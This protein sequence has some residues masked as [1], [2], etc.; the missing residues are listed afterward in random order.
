MKEYTVP[1]RIV[2][3]VMAEGVD[4]I[5]G[6]PDPSFFAMFLEAE[7][8]GM[9]IIAPHHEQAGALMADG[10][11]R[12]TGKPGVMGINKGPGVAN[13][14]AGAAYLAKENIPAV[15]IMGQRQRLYEQRVRRGKMQYMS[16]P[17]IFAGMMKYMGTIEYP[18]QTDEIIH[19]AF[20]LAMSGVPGPTFVEMPLSVMQPKLKLPPALS[21][22]RYRLANQEAGSGAIESAVDILTSAKNPILLIGQGAFVSRAHADVAELATRLGCPIVYSSAVEAVIA[23]MD[24]RSFPYGSLSANEIVGNADAVVAIGTELG[25]TLHYGR[26][27][28]WSKGC[29]DRKWIYIERDPTAIGVNRPIDVPL[30]GDLRDIVPQLAKTLPDTSRALPP[31]VGEL[32]KA[33]AEEKRKLTASISTA[34]QP[35]HPGRLAIEATKVLPEDVVL[36]RDGG[37]SSM[38]FSGLL[39]CVP[40]DA[41]WNSNYG[42]VGP[43]LPY[44]VGAQLAVGDKRRVVLVTGDSSILFH[45]SEI[46]TAVRENLPVICIVAVDHA[47]GIE[48]ASYKANFGPETK[49]PGAHWNSKVRL[50]KTAESF[51]AYGEYVERAEDVGPA[52][53]RALASGKPA[54]IHCVIDADANSSFSGLPGFMEFRTWYGEEGDNLGFAGTPPAATAQADGADDAPVNQGSGY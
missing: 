32:A 29:T 4:T 15:F 45:I 51:G 40:R 47:W 19:E 42:A 16:Q 23:G 35:M 25:E 31:R 43:G 46:E 13:I 2:E 5:F 8:R 54:V 30:V 7:R 53:E 14:A 17:P 44:A 21:P 12:L 1:E 50:D 10:Y 49:K 22:S 36:V 52:V 9:R 20:R 34:S 41:M 18:E 26:G 48:V 27:H 37:A 11:Y 28:H 24:D 39:Q 33:H 38:W 3:L 6:I